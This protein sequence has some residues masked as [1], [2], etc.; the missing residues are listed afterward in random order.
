MARHTLGRDIAA[1]S[2]FEAPEP[3][4][5]RK[6]ESMVQNAELTDSVWSKQRR[7]WAQRYR[8]GHASHPQKAMS[9]RAHCLSDVFFCR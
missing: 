5:P 7:V 1:Q 8:D 3:P 9:R 2:L 4:R 6:V